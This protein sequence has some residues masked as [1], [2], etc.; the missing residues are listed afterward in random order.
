MNVAC[1]SVCLLLF[2]IGAEI[3][4]LWRDLRDGWENSTR[5]KHQT[6]VNVTIG[7]VVAVALLASVGVLGAPFRWK[8]IQEMMARLVQV[9]TAILIST[10]IKNNLKIFYYTGR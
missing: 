9:C 7:D 6:A 10:T 8:Y 3:W 4:G 1:C 2:F 5:L